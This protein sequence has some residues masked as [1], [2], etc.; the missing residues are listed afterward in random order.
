MQKLDRVLDGDD[1]S[2]TRRVD[3][4]DHRCERRGLSRSGGA[5]YQNQ[6]AA[7]VGDAVDYRRQAKLHA[8]LA[9][10]GNDPQHDADAAALLKNVSAKSAQTF[11]AVSNVDLRVVFIFMLLP[12]RHNLECHVSRVLGHDVWRL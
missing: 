4:I 12:I 11:D 2:R 7:L 10:I 9:L 1:V 6:P 8:V 3:S 5:G